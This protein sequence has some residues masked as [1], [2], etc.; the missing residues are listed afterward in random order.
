[1]SIF[2]WS[3]LP[4]FED[5][6]SVFGGREMRSRRRVAGLLRR[7]ARIAGAILVAVGASAWAIAVILPPDRRPL[8]VIAGGTLAT[9][10]IILIAT[11]V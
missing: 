4:E 6:V 2:D 3:I 9:G 7:T 5:V 8:A 10:G 11:S 1:M